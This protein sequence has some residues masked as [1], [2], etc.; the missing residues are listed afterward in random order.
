[1]LV[2]VSLE[3]SSHVKKLTP[4]SGAEPWTPS[5]VVLGVILNELHTINSNY[6]EGLHEFHVPGCPGEYILHGRA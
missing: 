2:A 1:M 3:Q 5:Y 6:T 4:P